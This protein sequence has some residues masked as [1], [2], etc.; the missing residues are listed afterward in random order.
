MI[1]TTNP[2]RVRK[3]GILPPKPHNVQR[4]QN[5]GKE[6]L[7]PTRYGYIGLPVYSTTPF[8]RTGRG[9]ETKWCR[10][11]EGSSLPPCR[12]RR[13]RASCAACREREAGDRRSSPSR[14][15]AAGRRPE[16]AGEEGLHVCWGGEAGEEH[17]RWGCKA[18][19]ADRRTEQ[20]KLQSG[21]ACSVALLLL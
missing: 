6:G 2:V 8:S 16:E 5:S 12:P 20:K 19:A 18:A 15:A 1:K 14:G 10:M 13:R 7:I 3:V 4:E 11:E 9:K 21:F 17:E